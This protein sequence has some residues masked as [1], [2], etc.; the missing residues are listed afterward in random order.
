MSDVE[1]LKALKICSANKGCKGCSYY[2]LGSSSCLE[3]VC[4]DAAEL[5][6]KQRAEI[7]H[8]RNLN[9]LAEQDIADRD[10]MLKQKVEDVYADF[11]K[12]YRLM[13]EE[14]NAACDKYLALERKSKRMIRLD[15]EHKFCHVIGN[16]HVYTK[17][18]DDYYDLKKG[19]G[20][21]AIKEFAEVLKARAIGILL[22]EHTLAA[23]IDEGLR[24]R[25]IVKEATS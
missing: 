17:T 2:D 11:M 24:S 5:I 19:I 22:D 1:I 25:G 3:Q 20:N 16:A 7:E 8:L 18:L 15:A 12:D 13:E 23:I 6:E 9:L 10:K 21:Q 4:K 14:L